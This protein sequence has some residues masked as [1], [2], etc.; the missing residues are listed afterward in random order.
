MENTFENNMNNSFKRNWIHILEDYLK[1]K[2]KDNLENILKGY[3]ESI[4]C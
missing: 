2:S 4:V 1:N 3:L